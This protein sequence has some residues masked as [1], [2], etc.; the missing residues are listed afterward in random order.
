MYRLV[1][2][3]FYAEK[4]NTGDYY[5]EMTLVGFTWQ[6]HLRVHQ[7]T[8]GANVWFLGALHSRS[9]AP[10]SP[11][12]PRTVLYRSICYYDFNKTASDPWVSRSQR[13]WERPS[14]FW[15]GADTG[16][17]H[18]SPRYLLQFKTTIYPWCAFFISD[19]LDAVPFSNATFDMLRME[20]V[21]SET[22]WKK[23][24]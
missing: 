7:S 9:W 8:K 14:R 19:S 12:K 15:R 17:R 22:I 20:S 1:H 13:P 21:M 10:W 6:W 3:E 4:Y 18:W 11:I 2:L 23:A 5:T 16:V 24:R